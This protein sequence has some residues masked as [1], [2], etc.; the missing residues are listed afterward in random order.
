MPEGNNGVSVRD[1]QVSLRRCVIADFPD[2]GEK[3]SESAHVRVEGCE[4]VRSGYDIQVSL[5]RYL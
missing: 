3:G 4:F 5:G 2:V 1:T